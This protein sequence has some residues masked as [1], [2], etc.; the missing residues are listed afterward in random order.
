M[1]AAIALAP[2]LA[3]DTTKAEAPDQTKEQKDCCTGMMGKDMGNMMGMMGMG[4]MTSNWKDQEAELD[5]LVG[6]M[7]SAPSDKKVD[8]ITAVVTKLVEQHKAIHERMQKM[9]TEGGKDM[10][11]MGRMMMMMRMMD[12]MTHGDKENQEEGEHSQHH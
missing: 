4:D 9:M 11:K 8:A 5:K 2:V 12:M 7:N 3:E 1:A 6:E 10:M